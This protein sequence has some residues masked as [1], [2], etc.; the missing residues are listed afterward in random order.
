M[1][2]QEVDYFSD[3][4]ASDMRDSALLT[5]AKPVAAAWS[6][7][8]EVVSLSTALNSSSDKS[9][10]VNCPAGKEIINA[11]GDIINGDGGVTIVE[12]RPTV[13]SATV[14][15]YETDPTKKYQPHQFFQ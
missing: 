12:L 6:S 7:D 11:G 9:V 14:T 5:F 10:T 1:G 3:N 15:A 13:T 4:D 2:H 8:L